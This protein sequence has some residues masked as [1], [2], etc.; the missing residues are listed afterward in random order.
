MGWN[1]TTAALLTYLLAN[2]CDLDPGILV[3]SISDAHLYNTHIESGAVQKLL[4]RSPRIPPTLKILSKKEN[5]EDYE[6]D[7][8]V[9]ENYYPCPSIMAEMVA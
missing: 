4:E 3:H 2:H 8:L 9:I 5:I 1:T 6:F 7:D